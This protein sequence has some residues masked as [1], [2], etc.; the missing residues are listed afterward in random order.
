MNE[1]H[2]KEPMRIG[3]D[4]MSPEGIEE[5][6]HLLNGGYVTL[7]QGGK[8]RVYIT[9]GKVTSTV[10]IIDTPSE[11]ERTLLEAVAMQAM[12]RIDPK[13]FIETMLGKSPK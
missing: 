13:G 3:D 5:R 2:V 1:T 4:V 7:T 6:V 8:Y 11:A 12:A 9:N 10:R